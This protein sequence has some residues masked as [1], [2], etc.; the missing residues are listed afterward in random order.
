MVAFEFISNFFAKRKVIKTINNFDI[1]I[2]KL[3]QVIQQLKQQMPILKAQL[4]VIYGKAGYRAKFEEIKT[5]T[6]AS[7]KQMDNAII[8]ARSFLTK[9][10]NAFNP[11]DKSMYEKQL[12][13]A[14]Q[15]KDA[16]Q[17]QINQMFTVTPSPPKQAYYTVKPVVRAPPR[18]ITPKPKS[19]KP[20]SPKPASPKPVKCSGQKKKVC[21][22]EAKCVWVV[23]S[24]C[25]NK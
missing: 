20:K 12:E 24:G 13:I 14:D 7:V 1:V 25:K 22:S 8:E 15:F 16:F 23:G 4:K 6:A 19:P 11:K 3:P 2:T 18:I 9:N 5:T 21:D 10:P 17:A